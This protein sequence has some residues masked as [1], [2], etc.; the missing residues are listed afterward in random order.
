ME[1]HS[2]SLTMIEIQKCYAVNGMKQEILDEVFPT[3]NTTKELE[4]YRKQLL[5]KERAKH[6]RVEFVNGEKVLV[7]EKVDIYFHKREK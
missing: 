3:F 7:Q 5:I 6:T 4:A 2:L 1:V